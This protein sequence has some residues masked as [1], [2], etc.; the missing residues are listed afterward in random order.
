MEIALNCCKGEFA[1]ARLL[2]FQSLVNNRPVELRDLD[3]E[4]AYA[5]VGSDD[6]VGPSQER[7]RA[8]FRMCFGVLDKLAYALCQVF[9]VAQANESIA[10]E[11]FWNSP[12]ARQR[13]EKMNLDQ[14]PASRR[15]V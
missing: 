9:G 5:N 12:R 2:F 1:L 6:P 14:Q 4:T 8:S 13:W 15:S 11:R 3:G 10:F 7:L